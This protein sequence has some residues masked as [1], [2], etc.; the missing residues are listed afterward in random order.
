MWYNDALAKRDREGTPRR[1]SE[2][3]F[4]AASP[5]ERDGRSEA[6]GF[7]EPSLDEPLMRAA[8]RPGFEISKHNQG[9]A[10]APALEA[11]TVLGLACTGTGKTAA[12]MLPSPQRLMTSR[13]AGRNATT[14][15]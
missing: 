8:C 9:Q 2:R 6:Y 5:V 13:Q 10:I 7:T 4:V 12:H 1:D 11:E 3:C 15:R 14:S